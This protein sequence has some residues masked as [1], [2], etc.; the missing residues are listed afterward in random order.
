MVLN[1]NYFIHIIND[2]F[3]PTFTCISLQVALIKFLDI[4]IVKVNDN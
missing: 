2:T 1:N 3:T 4:K